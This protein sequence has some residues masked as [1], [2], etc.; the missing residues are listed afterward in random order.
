L[1]EWRASGAE[2]QTISNSELHAKYAVLTCARPPGETVAIAQSF[3]SSRSLRAIAASREVGGCF[4]D[5][6]IGIGT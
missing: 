3:D 5:L 2:S 1:R 6:W 4:E